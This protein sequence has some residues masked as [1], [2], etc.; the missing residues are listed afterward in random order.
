MERCAGS[1]L[2]IKGGLSQ[3]SPK[4]SEV[5]IYSAEAGKPVRVLT[6]AESSPSSSA[7]VA[8]RQQT[9]RPCRNRKGPSFAP[10]DQSGVGTTLGFSFRGIRFAFL[11][12]SD[13][14]PERN[15]HQAASGDLEGLENDHWDLDL[16]R[17]DGGKSG[18]HDVRERYPHCGSLG[19]DAVSHGDCVCF[20]KPEYGE[21]YADDG[22]Q[23]IVGD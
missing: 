16:G 3:P 15:R 8:S 7:Q 10:H 19:G 14:P 23:Y 5:K 22:P 4:F 17:G 13:P 18:E 11:V 6:N 2:G 12:G 20:T 21:G 9:K 1:R